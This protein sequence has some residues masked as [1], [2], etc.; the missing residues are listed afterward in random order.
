MTID[1]WKNLVVRS[2][3]AN[4]ISLDF[5][6]FK[7]SSLWN[8]SSNSL[9][10]F[11]SIIRFSR[12]GSSFW[13][14]SII[15]RIWVIFRLQYLKHSLFHLESRWLDFWIFLHSEKMG[16]TSWGILQAFNITSSHDSSPT[17]AA[18]NLN[19]RDLWDTEG[20]VSKTTELRSDFAA[21]YDKFF[22][23]TNRW[24]YIVSP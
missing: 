2:P 21:V 6:R 4:Q 19:N 5:Y 7:V 16:L 14:L 12:L 9:W 3:S 20:D 17:Q 23:K 22:I 10:R 8:H 24:K 15:D 13:I 1:R 11:S 18:I